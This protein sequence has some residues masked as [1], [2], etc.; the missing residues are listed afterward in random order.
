MKTMKTH[1]QTFLILMYFTDKP[2]YIAKLLACSAL[3]TRGQR[4]IC[5]KDHHKDVAFYHMAVLLLSRGGG[6]SCRLELPPCLCAHN[7]QVNL[8]MRRDRHD[9]YYQRT[10]Q[11]HM[12]W[13]QCCLEAMM[14]GELVS[15]QSIVKID[16]A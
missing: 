14:A 5:T 4:S 15:R 8:R 2:I 13:C 7:P 10:R 11:D 9:G 6:S 3:F 1:S 16:R 12:C